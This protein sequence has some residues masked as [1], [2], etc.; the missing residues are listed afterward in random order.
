MDQ[1]KAAGRG[2]RSV[3]VLCLQKSRSVISINAHFVKIEPVCLWV[4]AWAVSCQRSISIWEVSTG[5]IF[6]LVPAMTV[7]PRHFRPAGTGQR[8]FGAGSH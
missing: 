3:G 1:R 7:A 4:G 5:G 8:V 2:K 6:L